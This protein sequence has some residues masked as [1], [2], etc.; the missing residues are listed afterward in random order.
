VI[1]RLLREFATVFRWLVGVDSRVP[2]ALTVSP[3]LRVMRHVYGGTA[4]RVR[5][6]YCHAVVR[7]CLGPS[8]PGMPDAF[9]TMTDDPTFRG[10]LTE[11]M[12]HMASFSCHRP[13]SFHTISF[14]GSVPLHT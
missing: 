1:G 9:S 12:W 4:P 5:D 3:L 10:H 14:G 6:P 13:G 11:L 7:A 2:K 8:W